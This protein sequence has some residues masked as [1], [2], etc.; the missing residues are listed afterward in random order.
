M[1]LAVKAGLLEVGSVGHAGFSTENLY[2]ASPPTEQA[3]KDSDFCCV[4]AEGSGRLYVLIE[5][6]KFL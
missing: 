5:L 6:T 2:T 3:E 4:L 1:H